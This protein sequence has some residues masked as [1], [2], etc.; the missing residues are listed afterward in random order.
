M[1]GTR[2]TWKARRLPW[3]RRKG[4][5]PNGR[6]PRRRGHS[7]N[8]MSTLRRVFGLCARGPA[9]APTASWQ[10]IRLNGRSLPL[11][12]SFAAVASPRV[13]LLDTLAP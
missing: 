9:S 6:P 12:R 3:S 1:N 5:L 11:V 2:R 4:P 10:M 13:A 7:S 8:S